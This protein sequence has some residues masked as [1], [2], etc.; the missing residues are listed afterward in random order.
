M[1][2][3]RRRFRMKRR[4]LLVVCT[5]IVIAA[6]LAG[7]EASA[8]SSAVPAPSKNLGEGSCIGGGGEELMGG[9]KGTPDIDGSC[10]GYPEE[11]CSSIAI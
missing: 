7:F 3:L 10:G 11:P 2:I 8:M 6:S 4:W 1:G 5:A 9:K